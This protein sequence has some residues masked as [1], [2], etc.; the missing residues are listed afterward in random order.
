MTELRFVADQTLGR[1][2]KWLRLLG[3]DCSFI[4]AKSGADIVAIAENE[5]R[6]ILTRDTHLARRLGQDEH[7]FIKHDDW[8]NQLNQ[9]ISHY[10]LSM[11]CERFL[12]ICSEC[13]QAL[14][15]VLPT[16]VRG[17]VPPY[18]FATRKT[19]RKCPTCGRIYWGGTHKK[20]MIE[21]LKIL[22][23]TSGR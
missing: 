17:L 21:R 10:N 15:D 19:F 7:L 3:F 12:S 14:I 13:N 8:R 2:A 9:I 4:R 22:L 18:V 16:E 11:R 20:K 23:D 1:L 5:R 6:I